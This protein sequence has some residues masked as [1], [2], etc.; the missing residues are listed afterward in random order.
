MWAK[1]IVANPRFALNQAIHVTENNKA[2][3]IP[4][5]ISGITMFTLEAPKTLPW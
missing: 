2:K 5:I 4:V 1:I 3:L